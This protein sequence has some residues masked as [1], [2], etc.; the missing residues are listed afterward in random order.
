MRGRVLS[1]RRDGPAAAAAAV[2]ADVTVSEWLRAQRQTDRLCEWLWRP[3]AIAAL[4]QSADVAA[5]AEAIVSSMQ[6]QHGMVMVV[7]PHGLIV[8]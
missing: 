8:R 5:A 6:G 2:P 7:G 3:L 1:R 4:N